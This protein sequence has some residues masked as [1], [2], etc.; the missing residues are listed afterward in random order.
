M[1]TLL[2]LVP[3]FAAYWTTLQWCVDRWNA[4]TEYFAHCFLVPVVGAVVVWWRR[5]D[6]SLRPAA[7]D[8]RGWWLL[9]PGL[10]LHLAGASLM[11]DSWSAMSLVL[12]VPGAAWLVLGRHRLH[13]LWPVLWLVLFA[14]PLPIYVEGRLAFVLK[15]FA[16]QGGSWLANLFGADVQQ[17]GDRLQPRGVQGSLY[18]ADACGGL[19]SLLAMLTLAYCLSFFSGAASTWRRGLLLLAAPLLAIGANTVRIAVLCLLAR[20]FGVPFAEGNGHTLAN[21]AEWVALV[22][23]LLALDAGLGRWFRSSAEPSPPPP[24]RPAPAGR[25]WR[26]LALLTALAVPLLWLSLHRPYASAS[27]RARQLP[28]QVAG[29]AL[30]PRS[31]VEERQFEQNLPRWRELLGTGDFVWR[32]YR[33]A[34]GNWI[35]LVALFHDSN[36]KSVHPPRICIEGSNMDILVDDQVPADWLRG[37]VELGRIVARSRSDGWEYVT[38]SAFGTEDWVAGDYW[39]FTWHHLPRALVRAKMAGFLLRVESPVRK[40]EMAAAAQL[41]C[42]RFLR[43]LLPKAQELLR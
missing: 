3:L 7:I 8:P 36:W 41:R 23:A 16:V 37:D 9:G 19:R 6:W 35:N 4:P 11:V 12:T 20:W 40:D 24:L 29:F 26:T 27:A 22:L 5:R 17:L 10:L 15:E 39:D 42:D 2:L 1:R 13:G 31:E 18:V 30:V 33:D 14:V 28:D 32:R 43:D 21:I 38:L 25:Q 34:S